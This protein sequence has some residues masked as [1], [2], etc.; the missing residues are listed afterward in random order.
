MNERT[1]FVLQQDPDI[2]MLPFELVKLVKLAKFEVA[3]ASPPLLFVLLSH[4]LTD[5][6]PYCSGVETLL[7]L[8]SPTLMSQGN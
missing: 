3:L 1:W 4:V 2:T 5:R 6:D 8:L 7:L